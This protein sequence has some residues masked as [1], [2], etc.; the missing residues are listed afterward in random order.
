MP[1]KIDGME[2]P[3]ADEILNETQI[4]PSEE[5]EMQSGLDVKPTFLAVNAKSDV[6]GTSSKKRTQLK[7]NGT[8][9]VKIEE[10]FTT[11]PTKSKRTAAAL[12]DGAADAASPKTPTSRKR[13][14]PTTPHTPGRTIPTNY[15]EASEGD[16]M[17]LKMKEEGK[18]W[19]EIRSMWEEITGEKTGASTLP[20]RLARLQAN[21]T[22]FKEGDEALLLSLKKDIE[23]KFELE[24]WAKIAEAMEAAGSIKYSTKALEKKFHQLIKGPAAVVIAANE[25]SEEGN[26]D[27]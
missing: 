12:G 2:A 27:D 21:M 9:A 15:A 13:A 10:P 16:K 24:K 1:S 5:A 17:L 26:N 18:P 7:L 3:Q 19:K 22:I 6:K 8:T 11:T 20:N 25:Q 23:A 14:K 4:S